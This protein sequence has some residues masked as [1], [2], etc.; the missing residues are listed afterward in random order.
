MDKMNSLE[1][2]TV[3]TDMTKRSLSRIEYIDI[4]RAFGII[5]MVMGHIGFGHMFDHFIHAFHMPMFFF[6]SGFLYNNRLGFGKLLKKKAR[7]LLLPYFVF[8]SFHFFYYTFL[9]G[10]SWNTVKASL[11]RPTSDE[12]PIAGALW[13]LIALFIA[14]VLYFWI[15]K[16]RNNKVLFVAVL[17]VSLGGQILP[18]ILN[19]NLPFAG[20]AAMVGVGL[21]YIGRI[22]R[23]YEDRLVNFSNF[24]IVTLGLLTAVSIMQSDY[25]NMRTGSYSDIFIVFWINAIFSSIVG[26]NIAKKMTTFGTIR[27]LNKWLL[28]IGRNS[29][30][31]VCLNQIVILLIGSVFSRL[32]LIPWLNCLLTLAATLVVL[33]FLSLLFEKTVFRVCIGR[34]LKQSTY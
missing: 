14:D 7:S 23:K 25:I 9:Y 5:L 33:Y 26:L 19:I 31:Y 32:F 17:L 10:F 11:F 8:C 13:F 15:N 2:Q 29:I 20:G 6:V 22:C 24:Q 27:M 3:Q 34:K 12:M 1:K 28:S 21:M 18:P 4:F 30:V 16:I